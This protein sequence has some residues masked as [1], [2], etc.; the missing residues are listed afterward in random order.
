MTRSQLES[1]PNLLLLPQRCCRR[2]AALSVR[3]SRRRS[4]HHTV[5]GMECLARA[6]EYLEDTRSFGV[7]ATPRKAAVEQSIA[8]LKTCHRSAFFS[9]STEGQLR[10][11][12]A[13]R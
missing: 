10:A 7:E 9:C 4:D 1:L 2:F 3:L 11:A 8:I 12:K 5:H 6:V 13:F